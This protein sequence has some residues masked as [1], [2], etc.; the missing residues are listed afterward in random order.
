MAKKIE[1][2]LNPRHAAAAKGNYR[3]ASMDQPGELF[4]LT[5]EWQKLPADPSKELLTLAKVG[6][7]RD[8]LEIIAIAEI[9]GA[10]KQDDEEE[11]E[12]DA[13]SGKTAAKK[14]PKE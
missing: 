13:T 2:R 10:P 9:R 5:K 11:G 6:Y 8:K 1:A 14:S 4:Y 12:G 3:V 7:T